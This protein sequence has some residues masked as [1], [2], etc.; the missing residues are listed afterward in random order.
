M[1]SRS[2]FSFGKRVAKGYVATLT[3]F[4]SIEFR[5]TVCVQC[6]ETPAIYTMRRTIGETVFEQDVCDKHAKELK[7]AG[8]AYARKLRKAL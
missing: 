7:V 2:A 4:Q 5:G 8:W 6:N 1:V 3:I